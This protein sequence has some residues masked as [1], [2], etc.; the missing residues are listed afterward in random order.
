VQSNL[1]AKASVAT[2]QA[3]AQQTQLNL[4][5]ASVTSP[6]DGIAG[7]A[8]AQIGDLVGPATGNL[9]EVSTLDPSRPISP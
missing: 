4:D 2:A 6:I 8:R 5:F 3:A 7:M 9:T 1:A